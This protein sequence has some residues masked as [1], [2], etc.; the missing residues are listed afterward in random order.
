MPKL[1]KWIEKLENRMERKCGKWLERN[2]GKLWLYALLA[3][4]GLYFYGMLINSIRLGIASTFSENAGEITSI[5][6]VNPFRNLFAIFT[7]TGLATTGI[8]FLLFCLITKKG[9]IW[10]S[11]YKFKRD[12]RGFDI[13]PDATHGS[14]SFMERKEAAQVFTIGR[15]EE[16]KGN[17]YG[18]LKDAPDDDDKYADYVASNPQNGLNGN[19]LI[20]GAP[21]TGK[22]RGVIRPLIMSAVNRGE[23]IIVVDPKGELF[24][25]MGGY[26][27][28][29]GMIVK[30]L[31]LLDMISSD[32]FNC[33]Q[34]IEDDPDLVQTITETIIKN[35]SAVNE[36]QDF[37]EK[38]ESNLLSALIHYVQRQT[39]PGSNALLPIH[40]RSLGTIYRLLSD[41]SFNSLEQRFAELPKGHPA[42]APYGIF[43]LANRQIWGNIA[44]GLGNRLSVFQNSLVDKITAYNDIELQ[45]PGQVPCAYFCII[46]DQDSSLEFLSSLFFSMLFSRLTSYARRHGK[47]GRLPVTVNFVMDEFC[48]IGQIADFKRILSTARSRGINCQIVIQ[49]LAQL[50]DRYEKKEWEEIVGNCDQQ[51]ML[52]CNDYM[53][54][55]YWSKKIGVTS[56][57]VQTNQMPL[58][59]LFSPVYH[60]TRPYSQSSTNTQRALMTPDEILR[61]DSRKCILMCR[62][63]KPLQLY[64]IVPEECPDFKH[65]RPI[66]IA[67]YIPAW[68]AAEEKEQACSQQDESCGAADQVPTPEGAEPSETLETETAEKPPVQQPADD[69][70]KDAFKQTYSVDSFC[71]EDD[72]EVMRPFEDEDD[73]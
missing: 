4:A 8:C 2:R 5:W 57:R 23:S 66:T 71:T 11:G 42:R 37:W 30:C 14:A 59:P 16:L 41:E 48:N 49:S 44:I 9:Y 60:S 18:K 73:P 72:G 24:E 19:L 63:C 51:I 32:G 64:K 61:L 22:S 35:T 62:G 65:M 56:I 25:S 13:I 20:Y 43:K 58:M 17:I 34:D 55:D 12:P 1:S 52:G 68:R 54:A 28:D 50:A 69:G 40:E 7:P 53:T 45:L 47:N 15:I 29:R 6:V 27:Q 38:A 3:A 70:W 21:G 39:L 26:L 46:S 31:N 33:L 36:R 67:D 10:F